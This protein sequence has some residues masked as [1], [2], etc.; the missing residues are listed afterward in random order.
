MGTTNPAYIHP[1]DI[2]ELGLEDNCLV[3]IH[4]AEGSIPAVVCAY[5]RIKRGVIAMHHS[6]GAAPGPETDARVRDVGANTNRLIDNLKN[7]QRYTGMTQQS[8]IPIYLTR[9]EEAA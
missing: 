5:D 6:W 3:E 9:K 2:A 1:E 8:A 4:S 7:T